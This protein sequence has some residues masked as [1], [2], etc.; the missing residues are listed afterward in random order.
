MQSTMGIFEDSFL[1]SI[2]DQMDVYIFII[3]AATDRIVFMN[4]KMKDSFYID[5]PEGEICWK[6]LKK[7]QSAHCV[8]CSFNRLVEQGLTQSGAWE[9]RDIDSQRMLK[10]LDFRM[11]WEGRWYFIQCLSD[12]SEYMLLYENANVDELTKMLNRRAGKEKMWEVVK[13]A[14]KERASLTI[15]LCDVNELKLVNDLYG[16]SEGDRLLRYLSAM[17]RMELAGDDFVFRLSGD[18]FI[19]GFYGKNQ[20]ETQKILNEIELLVREKREEYSIYYEA[21]FSYGLFEIFPEDTY[22]LTEM[23]SRADENMYVQKKAYHIRRAKE[24]LFHKKAPVRSTQA[25]VYDKEHL[26]EALAVSSDDYLFV[27]NLKTGTFRYPPDMVAEFGL[28]GEVVEN[29][30]AYWGDIIHPHDEQG[31]LE[32]NQEITDGRAE[33]HDIE[34]R[35]KN[36]KG[37]WVWMR[38]RGRMIRDGQGRPELFAGFISNLGKNHT[39]DHMTGMPNKYAFEGDV[40]KS[41]MGSALDGRFAVMV[42]DMDS[43][44][45][46]NDLYNR[47]FGDEI[48]RITAQKI[49]AL[50]PPNA[51]LYR[52]DGDEFGIIINGGDVHDCVF[53]FQRI[54]HSFRRQQEHNGRKYHCSMS[55]GCVQFPED[56]ENYLDLLKYANYSLEYSKSMGK[57]RITVYSSEIQ[58][59]K[60]R[61][62]EILEMLRES[63]ERG[64]AGFS[65]HYQ[66]QVDAG[67]GTLLGAE[68]LARWH[69]SKFGEVP[70]SEFIPLLEQSGLIVPVGRWIFLQAVQQCAKWCKVYPGFQMSINLSYRQLADD[71]ILSFINTVLLQVKLDAGHVTMELTESYLG[72]ADEVVLDTINGMRSMGIRVAMDDF[73]IGYSSLT[74]LKKLPVDIVKI[75]R[76]FAKEVTT[77]LFNLA[78]IRAITELCHDVGR[79]V[80]LEGIE[81]EE[82]YQKVKNMGIEMI[83]GYYFG[84]PMDAV[85]FEKVMEIDRNR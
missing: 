52:M 26:Y 50:L 62:L 55:A 30:A 39:L 9:K 14:R 24:N 2:L 17:F 56:G 57:N 78:M 35:L 67:T 29:A 36:V 1:S 28:P 71:N 68:A 74:S 72:Q 3:D 54:Q 13:K 66:P 15:A 40:K 48:L 59:K 8:D 42:M 37:D 80:C 51:A 47:S 19:M 21:S 60:E 22:D 79:T 44:K 31:F 20:Q 76:S 16:H 7:G 63:I 73:G 12:I 61:N 81:Q 5:E 11:E 46:I 38:C 33:Y 58:V 49:K 10:A 85:Q 82:Q 25:F 45:N 75:D 84:R 65:I 64:Y 69:C 70:P 23:I 83:Q 18:E 6:V 34:Y 43:F 53:L 4:K 32:S 77:D 41:L 27:G